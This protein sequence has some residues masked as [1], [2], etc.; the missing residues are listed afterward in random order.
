M[1]RRY[2]MSPV[3]RTRGRLQ[4]AA[5]LAEVL[6]AAYDAF[7]EMLLAIRAREDPASGLFAAF[8]MAAASAAD[9]RDAVAFAP[10]FPCPGTDAPAL[11][12]GAQAG[13]SAESIAD[14]VAGLSRLVVA[15]LVQARESS[16]DPDDRAACA[17]AVC[18]AEN[19][20]GLLHRSGP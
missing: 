13:E 12:D 20:C 14:A 2:D 17:D 9:G 6:D 10:S 11:E 7:E 1:N 18:C 3:L 16:P 5:G 19:I 4:H 8:M 15:R